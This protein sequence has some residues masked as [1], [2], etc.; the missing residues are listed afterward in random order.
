MVAVIK[1]G[2]SIRRAFLYNENKVSEGRATL[3][4][5]QNYP[6]EQAAMARHHRLNMLLKMAERN[7]AV[8]RNSV[9]ISLNFAPGEVISPATMN[10]IAAEYMEAI[11][12]GKQPYLVYQHTDAG[13][14]HLHVVT[15][16]VDASGKR[17]ET[18]NIGKTLSEAARKT[19][20]KRHNLVPAESH[21]REA[22]RLRPVT[23][24]KAVYGATDTKRAIANVLEHVLNR[25]RYTSLS[26]LNAILGLYNVHAEQGEEGSRLRKYRGLQYRLLGPE[27]KPI[28]VPV[29]A[30]LFH[31][32]PTLARLQRRFPPNQQARKAHADRL[33]TELDAAIR[34][35]GPRQDF[36]SLL[37][38]QGIDL[39]PRYS[40]E[41]RLYG[42]TY[43]DHRSK[44]VFNGSDL[45]KAYSAN[46][47][48]PLLAAQSYPQLRIAEK[49]QLTNPP[50]P[51]HPP[52]PAGGKNLWDLLTE[53]IPGT[54]Y[55]P[56]ELRPRRKKRRK[57]RPN[58]L[59]Q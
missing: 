35:H 28:G 30:S 5:V 47:V 12:F 10:T 37:K 15:V 13:H 53:P 7:P 1:T 33:R 23:V 27:G 6:M 52:N 42:I 17:L 57:N 25:Y 55:V 4:G 58:N 18:Q 48:A 45:G 21:R 16:K 36:K 14:P 41:G 50:T 59:N 31:N 3:I 51:L 8:S 38:R 9:H 24:G 40:M 56:L 54:D 34:R 39:V 44:C 29:K 43:V 32:R 19:I 26:E 2:H 11:G 49:S 46:A 22:F 20:E